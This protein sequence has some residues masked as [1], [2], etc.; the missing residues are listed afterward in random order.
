M[1]YL[2]GILVFLLTIAD[3]RR[4]EASLLDSFLNADLS[5]DRGENLILFWGVMTV[6]LL[7]AAA[8]LLGGRLVEVALA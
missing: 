6:Q 5:I 8:L 2:P 7:I 3:I 4:G 1:A